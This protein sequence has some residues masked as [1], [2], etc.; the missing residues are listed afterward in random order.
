MY[1]TLDDEPAGLAAQQPGGEQLPVE[2]E[3]RHLACGV[4]R[5]GGDAGRAVAGPLA[6][7]ALLVGERAVVRVGEAEQRP[8]VGDE[9]LLARRNVEH[10]ERVD[11]I[12]A[13]AAAEE[14]DPVAVGRHRHVA[15]LAQREAL[16]AGVLAGERIAHRAT[17]ERG[18]DRFDDHVEGGV[19]V[20]VDEDL[21]VRCSTVE[22]EPFVDHRHSGR[23]LADRLDDDVTLV[24]LEQIRVG[25]GQHGERIVQRGPA[26]RS[27][28][29][30]GEVRAG[31]ELEQAGQ[32]LGQSPGELA[33]A[34][35]SAPA[36][37]GSDASRRGRP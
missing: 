25:D 3:C 35:R 37:V 1:G 36:S 18:S 26:H 12:V 23:V 28:A 24:P 34:L 14:H 30:P 4:G 15:R 2:R 29:V 6:A 9:S 16:C 10:P 8:R 19:G 33:G 32:D 11:G 7:G 20:D 27:V 17:I 22:Q 5:V 21:A 31:E 13:G